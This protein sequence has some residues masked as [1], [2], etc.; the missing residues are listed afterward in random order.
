MTACFDV[1]LTA[2]DNVFMLCQ[3]RLAQRER[4]VQK[5]K[6]MSATAH[7]E[8][9][10]HT[11]KKKKSFFIIHDLGRLRNIAR[12]MFQHDCNVVL[13]NSSINKKLKLID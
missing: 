6:Q 5:S 4:L 12:P 13:Y 2:T 9:Y 1:T 3:M 8:S 7:I 10:M 11:E